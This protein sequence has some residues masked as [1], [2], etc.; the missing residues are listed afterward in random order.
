MMQTEDRAALRRARV[1]LGHRGGDRS[2]SETAYLLYTVSLG[3]LIAGVPIIRTLVLSLSEPAVVAALTALE[4]T[5]VISIGALLLLVIAVLAGGVRGAIVPRP[6]YVHLF[7]GSPLA[8]GVVLRRPFVAAQALTTLLMLSMAGI[9]CG[10]LA[11]AGHPLNLGAVA[12]FLGAVAGYSV[13]L[14]TVWLIGQLG[15]SVRALVAWSLAFVL[16]VSIAMQLGGT[17]AHLWAGPWGWLATAWSGVVTDASAPGSVSGSVSV[18]GSLPSVIAAL[19]CTTTIGLAPFSHLLLARVRSADLMTQSQAWASSAVMAQTGD[20]RG[21][22]DRVR[23]PP[24]HRPRAA[25]LQT[26]PLWIGVVR[27]DLIGILRHPVRA[28]AGILSGAIAGILL[29]VALSMEPGAGAIVA[30]IAG[31][32]MYTAAGSWTDGLRYHADNVGAQPL[33]GVGTEQLALLHALVPTVV[34]C[35]VVLV[36]AI[37]ATMATLASNGGTIDAFV[38]AAALALALIAV[39]LRALSA[40]KGPIPIG[41]LLPIPT[42]V[43][44][45][46]ILNALIWVFDGFLLSLV[47]TAILTGIALTSSVP[48]TLFCT[49]V[50]LVFIVIWA[51]ARFRRLRL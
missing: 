51:R 32:L 36:G 26:G 33:Y 23:L 4:A 6:A 24:R 5:G 39:T 17:E 48:L 16:L 25:M 21:S 41:L 29:V 50:S 13:V 11:V 28:G 14:S 9:V 27:R 1:A 22:S 44:D 49:V 34:S 18:P 37:G 2:G 20:V 3:V 30:A 12:L 45:I 19:L 8:R 38:C 7:V 15:P 43:G 40:G 47:V 10:A 31:G 42:P 35:V 46:S